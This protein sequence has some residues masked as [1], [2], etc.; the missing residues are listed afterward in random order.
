MRTKIELFKENKTIGGYSIAV[1]DDWSFKIKR[2][3]IS[4]SDK[5][6]YVQKFGNKIILESEF[7]DWWVEV[8]RLKPSSQFLK[9]L[10]KIS[11][12]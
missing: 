7:M 8:N 4:E 10:G 1:R 3:H 5:E 6:R 11:K 9:S 2:M 12:K